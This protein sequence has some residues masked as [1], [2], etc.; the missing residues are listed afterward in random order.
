[1]MHVGLFFPSV[2]FTRAVAALSECRSAVVLVHYS[3]DQSCWPVWMC[4][5][6][7]VNMHRFVV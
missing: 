4:C 5:R 1:M 2:E 3:K 6:K 7:K